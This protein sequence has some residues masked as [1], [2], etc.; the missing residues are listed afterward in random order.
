MGACEGTFLEPPC[1]LGGGVGC[2]MGARSSWPVWAGA[3]AARAAAWPQP[4]GVPLG[5]SRE[6][7]EM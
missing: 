2:S 1:R 7:E 5:R 3:R 6:C 4:G